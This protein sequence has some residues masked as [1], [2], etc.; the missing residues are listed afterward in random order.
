LSQGQNVTVDVLIGSKCHCG[1]S[2]LGRF[3]QAS[4]RLL[5][6]LLSSYYRWGKYYVVVVCLAVPSRLL[7]FINSLTSGESSSFCLHG[8]Q[9]GSS[10][11]FIVEKWPGLSFGVYYISP[12]S[13]FFYLLYFLPLPSSLSLLPFPLSYPLFL[14]P[15][16]S[17]LSLLSNFFRQ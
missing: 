16:Y 14:S 4:Q 6:C 8:K 12:A 17:L 10:F 9:T 7:L 2:E 11:S 13:P 15:F 3:V 1:R 5:T